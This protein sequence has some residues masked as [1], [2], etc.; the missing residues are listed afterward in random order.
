MVSATDHTTASRLSLERAS[1]A[2]ERD[3]V[4]EAAAFV[5]NAA[6]CAMRSIA[7]TRGW[8]IEIEYDLVN[9]AFTLARETGVDE[10]STLVQVASTAPWLIEEGWIDKNWLVR[11]IQMVKDLLKILDG[12]DIE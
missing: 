7:E 10:I 4:P 2:L 8:R 11:D 5:W 9:A 12:L 1:A 6:A 3:D